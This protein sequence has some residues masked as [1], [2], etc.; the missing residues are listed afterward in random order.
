M[1]ISLM[2]I[3]VGLNGNRMK[4]DKNKGPECNNNN[5]VKYIDKL[6]TTLFVVFV[7]ISSFSRLPVLTMPFHR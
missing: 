7:D 2:T 4:N 6:S 3:F 5:N 1:N